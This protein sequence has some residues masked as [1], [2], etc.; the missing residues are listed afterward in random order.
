M[1]T[2]FIL[3]ILFSVLHTTTLAQQSDSL[4]FNLYTDSLKKGTWNYINVEYKFAQGRVVPLTT[5]QIE[6]KSDRGIWDGTSLW[7]DWQFPF[8]YVEVEVRYKSNSVLSSKKII[9][10]RQYD[11][12]MQP[13]Q[14]DSL[15][16]ELN[17]RNRRKV[18]RTKKAG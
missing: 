14:T 3:L 2:P 4:Y 6:L 12:A 17:K 7:I 8:P 15:L 16:N 10:I 18:E 13:S 5:P 9:W 1:K 11:D